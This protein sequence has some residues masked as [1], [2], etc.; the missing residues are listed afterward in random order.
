MQDSVHVQ[1]G[2]EHGDA[3]IA[4]GRRIGVA[5]K[6]KTTADVLDR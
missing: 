2:I 5:E 1:L 4:V 6:A 3:H